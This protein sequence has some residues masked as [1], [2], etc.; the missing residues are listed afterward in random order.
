MAGKTVQV[1]HFG[2]FFFLPSRFNVLCLAPGLGPGG[3]SPV[4]GRGGSVNGDDDV[5]GLVP[6]RGGRV[7][8]NFHPIRVL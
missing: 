5:V 6:C 3:G 4:E 1:V 7:A 8:G 2:P